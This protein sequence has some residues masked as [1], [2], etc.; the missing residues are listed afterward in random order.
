MAA[1]SIARRSPPSNTLI[2]IVCAALRPTNS[3]PAIAT[4]IITLRRVARVSGNSRMGRA[5]EASAPMIIHANSVGT[6][7][8]STASNAP[9][10]ASAISVPTIA[11]SVSDGTCLGPRRI[12][13]HAPSAIDAPTI[14]SSASATKPR[15]LAIA[16]QSLLG[17]GLVGIMSPASNDGSPGDR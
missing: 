16:I 1:A 4:P 12:R 8:S 3:R 7:S 2:A 9:T 17:H 5:D 11:R 6:G 13:A 10:T 15:S 14:A